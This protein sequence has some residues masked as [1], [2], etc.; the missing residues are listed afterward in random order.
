MGGIKQ[1][2]DF[3]ANLDQHL[4]D[5]FAEY[6]T[7]AYAVLFLVIFFESTITPILPGDSLIFAAGALATDAAVSAHGLLL[8]FCAATIVGMT[9]SYFVGKRVGPALFSEKRRFFTPERLERTRE[10]YKEYGVKTM[11]LSRFIPVVRTFAPIV[12][13]IAEMKFTVFMV[14]NVIGGVL[15]VGL[16]LYGGYFFGSLPVV[17]DNF[18]FIVFGV[19]VVSFIPL[20]VEW[21]RNRRRRARSGASKT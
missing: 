8:L 15:W 3:V 10:F 14:T 5:L 20:L 12:A 13:G 18:G 1:L 17:R 21:R 19:F 2:L 6:G 16:F 9:V 11:V 7:Y 4:L